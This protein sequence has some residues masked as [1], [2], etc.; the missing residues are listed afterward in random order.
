MTTSINFNQI[1][2]LARG[3]FAQM[4]PL[5]GTRATGTATVT[6]PAGDDFS[7][8]RN[9]Y[10]RAI[11]SGKARDD[12]IFKVGR[13]TDEAD[14]MAPFTVPGGGTLSVPILSNVGG[15]AQNLPADARLRFDPYLPGL[16]QEVELDAAITNGTNLCSSIFSE[17]VGRPALLKRMVFWQQMRESQSAADFFRAGSGEFPALMMVWTRTVPLQGRTTGGSQGNTRVGRGQ[18]EMREGYD[19]FI[20]SGKAE[21][22]TERRNEAWIGMQAA[23]A[24]LTDSSSNVDG[25]T[26]STLGGLEITDRSLGVA[27]D[28]HLIYRVSFFVNS[29]IEYLERREFEPW[30]STRIHV[31]VPGREAPEPTAEMELV[32]VEDEMP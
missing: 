17:F 27:A 9:T 32:D 12:L 24:L 28:A 25:E 29:T 30:D 4:W 15:A 18:R 6:A 2:A 23:C 20:G 10:L 7:L 31:F 26:L 21:G 16:E 22:A 11:V 19:L 5:T 1:D 14:P 13:N 3:I 8:P